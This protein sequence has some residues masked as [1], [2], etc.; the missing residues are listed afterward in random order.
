MGITLDDS[1]NLI[2]ADSYNDRI[3][4]FSAEGQFVSSLG[5]GNAGEGAFFHPIG[6]ATAPSGD[7]YVA[8]TGNSRVQRFTADGRFLSEW[9]GWGIGP[10]LFLG[11]VGIAVDRDGNVY[12]TDILNCRVREIRRRWA[13]SAK[14]GILGYTQS[15]VSSSYGYRGGRRGIR[16]GRRYAQ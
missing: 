10:G 3:Q 2:I 7:V 11:P 15:N 12:V 6:I 4:T 14:V 9:G 8:D 16:M 5:S 1:G 13:F